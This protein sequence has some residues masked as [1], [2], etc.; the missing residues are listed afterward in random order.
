ML[1]LQKMLADKSE[2][3]SGHNERERNRVGQQK[4]G[5]FLLAFQKSSRS[6]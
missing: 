6:G 2:I 4:V 5:V 1:K 3:S